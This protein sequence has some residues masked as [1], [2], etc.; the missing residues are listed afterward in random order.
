MEK[1]KLDKFIE[2]INNGNVFDFH[3]GYQTDDNRLIIRKNLFDTVI[4]FKSDDGWYDYE[5]MLSFTDINDISTYKLL[6]YYEDYD[7][8]SDPPFESRPAITESTVERSIR[9]IL[10]EFKIF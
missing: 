3:N 5:I 2:I 4:D 10:S 8:A 1:I 9:V 7:Y 6:S